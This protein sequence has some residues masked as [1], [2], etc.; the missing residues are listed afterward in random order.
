MESE[1]LGKKDVIRTDKPSPSSPVLRHNRTQTEYT[2]RLITDVDT[3]TTLKYVWNSLLETS[4][5]ASVF[6]SWE[7]ARTWWDCFS[8][9]MDK[10]FIVLVYQDSQLVG[11]APLFTR[12][13]VGSPFSEIRFIGT[14]EPSDS[15]VVTEDLD[16]ITE[17]K[18]Q[19]KVSSVVAERIGKWLTLKAPFSRFICSDIDR[20]R[21]IYTMLEYLKSNYASTTKSTRVRF[22]WQQSSTKPIDVEPSRKKRLAR[23][24]RA[25][26]KDGGLKRCPSRS[27]EEAKKNYAL[28][29]GLHEQR[30]K[31]KGGSG[32]FG[33]SMFN[34]FHLTLLERLHSSGQ[35]DIV[36]YNLQNK[37]LAA[38][39][40]L[41]TPAK[42][43]YYQSGFETESANRYMALTNA[44]YVEAEHNRLQGRFCYDFLRGTADSYKA[45]FGCASSPLYDVTIFG[46]R[47]YCQ[48]QKA[49]SSG[50]QLAVKLLRRRS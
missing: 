37:N 7:W 50:K 19:S 33:S 32:A 45:G 24:Q 23:S 31:S 35:V 6:Q 11:I 22:Y 40:C 38:L 18:H 5:Y 12:S 43:I 41:Y 20:E 48:L 4:E 21:P 36:M 3:F 25:L 30:W 1:L 49:L 26:E 29:K 42:T 16:L 14:G 34:Q 44:H 15:E 8:G 10:P 39:Y 28:L 47:G 46:T 13:R 27:L 2:S 17:R 9:T